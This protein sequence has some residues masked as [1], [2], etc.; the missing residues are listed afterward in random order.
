[1]SEYTPDKWLVVKLSSDEGIH[2]RVFGSWYGG[3]LGSDHWQMNSGIVKVTLT[4]K[5]YEF[6]GTSGSIYRCYLEHYGIHSF[7]SSVLRSMTERHKPKLIM[8]VMDEET[9][10]T[11][12]ELS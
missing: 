4:D 8:S 1:M 5:Y 10:F 9:D 2:Y 6:E 7:G 3:Y 12:L 11:R